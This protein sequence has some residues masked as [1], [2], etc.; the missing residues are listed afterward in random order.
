MIVFFFLCL[1]MYFFSLVCLFIHLFMCVIFRIY[2]VFRSASSVMFVCVYF[3]VSI[4]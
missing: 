4:Y 3:C 1:F 2:L